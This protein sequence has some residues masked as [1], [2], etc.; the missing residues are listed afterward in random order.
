MCIMSFFANL[1]NNKFP[2]ISKNESAV[3]LNSNVEQI[4]KSLAAQSELSDQ[5]LS[6]FNKIVLSFCNRAIINSKGILVGRSKS[7]TT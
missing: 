3:N 5:L 2:L 7:T 6:L 4:A 1:N